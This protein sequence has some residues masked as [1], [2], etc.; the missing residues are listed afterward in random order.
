MDKILLSIGGAS[1]VIYGVRLLKELRKMNVEIHL[2]ISKNAMDILEY[3]TSYYLEDIRKIADYFYDNSDFFAPPASG[4]FNI[5]AMVVVP[6]SL[7]TLSAIA[8][9]YSDT[10]TSRAALCILK[11]RRKLVLV[12]RETPLDLSAIENMQKV[13]LNGAIIMPASPGFYHKPKTIDDLID[14]IIGKILD[15]LGFTHSLYEHWGSKD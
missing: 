12:I 9:G 13:Y 10:L 2:I 14:F 1:G 4:S 3:E 15:Q 8:N 7:K 6:C 11:E 5:D